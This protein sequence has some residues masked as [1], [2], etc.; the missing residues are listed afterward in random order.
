MRQGVRRRCADLPYSDSPEEH[1][2][3]VAAVLEM[4]HA[5]GIRAHP[6]KSIFGADVIEYLGHNLSANGI[7]PHYAKVSAI[8]ALKPPRNVSKL[9]SHL[10]F[11]NYY[12]CY[13]PNMSTMT[14]GLTKLLRKDE[15]WVWGPCGVQQGLGRKAGRRHEL[16]HP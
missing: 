9:R 1:V 6:D 2:T 14:S 10:G 16:D 5:C 12:R 13:I 15:P 8:M 4:L 11:I 3:H 7:S